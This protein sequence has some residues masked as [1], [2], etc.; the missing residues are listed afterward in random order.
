M[1]SIW[2]WKQI[3]FVISILDIL[4]MKILYN[5]KTINNKGIFNIIKDI[6]IDKNINNKFKSIMKIYEKM[7]DKNNNFKNLNSLNNLMNLNISGIQNY[8]DLD[9]FDISNDQYNYLNNNN[10]NNL[11]NNEHQNSSSIRINNSME[12]EW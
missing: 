1:I 6:N 12:E 7:T 2:D 11:N 8:E 9:D 5:L 4:I 10:I 3:L